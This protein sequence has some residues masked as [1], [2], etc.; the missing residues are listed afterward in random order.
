MNYRHH[1]HAGNFADVMKHALWI[2]FLGRI[3]SASSAPV[4]ALETHAGAGLYDLRG[5]MALRSKEAADGVGRLLVDPDPPA[6]FDVLRRV[7]LEHNPDGVPTLYPGSPLITL[8]V[9][10]SKDRYCGFE[11]RAEDQLSLQTTLSR[12]KGP[13]SAKAQAVL[14]DGYAGLGALRLSSEETLAVLVDPP[15]ERG[16][17]ADQIAA[18]IGRLLAVRKDAAAAIWAPIKDLESF[19]SLLRKLEGLEPRGL[20]SAEARLRPLWDP[21]RMNGAAL[22]LVNGPDIRAEARE[23]CEWVARVCGEGQGIGRVRALRA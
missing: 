16:D 11:L 12:R 6:T 1:F 13:K 9:L 4:L 21:L 10:R 23:V 3:C 7:V 19:D 2:T 14:G 15:F 5:P 20:V 22:V 8:A 18:C 17:E